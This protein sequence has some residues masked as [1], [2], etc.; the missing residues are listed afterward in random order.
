MLLCIPDK[1]R[2]GIFIN[3]IYKEFLKKFKRFFYIRREDYLVRMIGEKNNQK[4]ENKS[5]TNKNI[6]K[7]RRK[8]RLILNILRTF[9]SVS[10]N[11][12]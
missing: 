7:L 1:V 8:I 3:F 12:K 10:K 11:D 9:K 4:N 2:R 6:L 5:I